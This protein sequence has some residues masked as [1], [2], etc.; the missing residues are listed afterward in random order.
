MPV[1]V[2]DVPKVLFLAVFLV[3]PDMLLPAVLAA[4]LVLGVPNT[5]V[6][7]DVELLVV[8]ALLLMLLL[9]ILESAGETVP[10]VLAL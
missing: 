5:G 8:L 6:L 9:L 2:L 10:E 7:T 3:V 4:A 1:P